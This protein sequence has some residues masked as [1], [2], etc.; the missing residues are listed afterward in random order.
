MV[1]EDKPPNIFGRNLRG[2]PRVA[3]RRSPRRGDT[4]GYPSDTL[5]GYPYGYPSDTLTGYPYG[6]PSDTLTGY[7]Y[8]GNPLDTL[9]DTLSISSLD[10]LSIP[11]SIPFRFTLGIRWR[12]PVFA[13]LADTP[14][15]VSLAGVWR[16]LVVAW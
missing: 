3:H 7:P 10:I 2:Y 14:I 11:F 13:I 16:F 5:T 12:S 6:Y 1:S 15:T 8:A 4:Y 9:F